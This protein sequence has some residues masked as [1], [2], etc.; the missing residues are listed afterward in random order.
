MPLWR[1]VMGSGCLLMGSPCDGLPITAQAALDG[2]PHGSLSLKSTGQ[3][4]RCDGL[5]HVHGSR[6]TREEH[7]SRGRDGLPITCQE[8]VMGC[9]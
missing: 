4:A 9:Q 6:A 7:G 5:P 8:D 3:E 1:D 2:L